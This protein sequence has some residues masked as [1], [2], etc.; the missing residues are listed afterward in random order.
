MITVSLGGAG[1]NVKIPFY[2]HNDELKEKETIIEE[3]FWRTETS[4]RLATGTKVTKSL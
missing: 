2:R 1:D 3:I 4:Y